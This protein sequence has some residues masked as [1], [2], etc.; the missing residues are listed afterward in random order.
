MI[1]IPPNIPV[2]LCTGYSEVVD[3]NKARAQGIRRFIQKTTAVPLTLR[4]MEWDPSPETVCRMAGSLLLG[5]CSMRYPTTV[6]PVHMRCPTTTTIRVGRLKI[7]P[8]FSALP[9]SL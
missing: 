2:I 5:N 8:A 1:Q 9:T 3:E 6:R 7:A 4:S